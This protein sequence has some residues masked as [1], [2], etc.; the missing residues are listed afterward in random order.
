MTTRFAVFLSILFAP[1]TYAVADD[2]PQPAGNQPS[3]AAE[4]PAA[5]PPAA[6]QPAPEQVQ[7]VE[8][9]TDYGRAMAEAHASRKMLLVWFYDPRSAVQDAQFFA[10]VLSQPAIVQRIARSCVPVK[11]ST[12]A[13]ELV[14]GQEMR[15]HGHRAFA[16]L[17]NRPGIVMVDLTHENSYQFGRVVSVYPFSRHYIP[18][19]KLAAML[20]LPHG[21]LTQR[22]LIL[23]VRT[24]PEG[25]ASA[26]TQVIPLLAYESEKH[27]YHQASINLQGHHNWESRF[28]SINSRLPGGLISQEVCAESWP[29]QS[30]VDA[31]EECVHSWRQ[32]SGHWSAVRSR[33]VFYGYD[34]KRGRNGIW[35]A[36]GIFARRG[37]Y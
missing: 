2:Q 14:N 16:E 30:M 23:A 29:G 8:W 28:H 4:S 18:A 31:A 3:A 17:L 26:S 12:L 1:L 25:P 34:M 21:S 33:H 7:T 36:T 24:H 10:N 9:L 6:A 15:L 5:T 20:D 32:S 11:V 13:T 22:T 37:G 27:A 35:Y 19:Y